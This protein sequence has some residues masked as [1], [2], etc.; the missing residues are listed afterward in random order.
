MAQKLHDQY[1]YSYDNLKV[2][3]GGWS[4]WK[5]KNA[6]DPAG[7]PIETGAATGTTPGAGKVLITPS[8]VIT[9]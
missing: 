7:Y 4:A 1:N 6:T 5:D 2:L 8:T 3:L 9:P